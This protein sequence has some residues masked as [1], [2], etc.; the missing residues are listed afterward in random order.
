MNVNG[1]FRDFFRINIGHV[2]VIVVF[3]FGLGVAWAKLDGNIQQVVTT[4]IIHYDQTMKADKV[5]QDAVD[6]KIG[7]Q[8]DRLMRVEGSQRDITQLTTAVAV[9]SSEVKTLQEVG[10]E[11]KAELQAI[12]SQR[13]LKDQSK[14][15]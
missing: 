2:A 3:V 11:L 4:E 13:Q 10:R 14:N 9:L 1:M 15:P 7:A 6:L 8:A 12:R 5:L